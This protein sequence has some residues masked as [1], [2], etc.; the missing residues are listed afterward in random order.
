MTKLTVGD[1]VMWRGSW[2]KDQPKEVIIEDIEICREGCKNGRPIKSVDWDTV[3][4]G[5]KIVVNLDNGHWAYGNQLTQI[6]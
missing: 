3:K 2:G 6:L 1:K 4:E 5:R